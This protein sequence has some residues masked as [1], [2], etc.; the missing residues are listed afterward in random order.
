VGV[1]GMNARAG[2]GAGWGGGGGEE[3]EN[4][5]NAS[6]VGAFCRFLARIAVLLASFAPYSCN[7]KAT[8]TTE[9]LGG[10]H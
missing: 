6:R 8:E 1:G 9:K 10:I 3:S 7:R 5:K 2:G 4:A